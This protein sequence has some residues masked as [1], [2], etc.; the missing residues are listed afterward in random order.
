LTESAP[1]AAEITLKD[2]LRANPGSV[3]ASASEGK[4]ALVESPGKA[5]GIAEALTSRDGI[6]AVKPITETGGLGAVVGKGAEGSKGPGRGRARLAVVAPV[7]TIPSV[8]SSSD[9]S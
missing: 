1:K 3:F 4:D 9:S 7:G 5:G 8:S 2:R 6:G